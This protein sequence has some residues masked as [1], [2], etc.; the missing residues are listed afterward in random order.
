MKT[1]VPFSKEIILLESPEKATTEI[2]EK[3][4]QDVL[5]N[6]K[7]NGAVIGISGGID[8]SVHPRGRAVH[9]AL[10]PHGHG[11]EPAQRD[12]PAAVPGGHSQQPGHGGRDDQRAIPD[13]QRLSAGHGG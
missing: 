10:L 13:P 5:V 11:P 6:F 3:L 8:S 4:R 2:I 1:K 7:R 9:A 12:D